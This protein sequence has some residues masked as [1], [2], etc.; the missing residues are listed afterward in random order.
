VLNGKRLLAVV[1][2]RGGS[3][4][5]PLKNLHP[6]MGRPLLAYAAATIHE[7]GCFD[8]GVVSTDH[9]EIAAVA[10]ASGLHVPFMRP[11]SLSG[12][13]IGD[14]PVLTHA[15][16]E[17]EASDRCEYDVI[18]ML[19]PTCPLRE[20]RHVLATVQRLIDEGWDAVWTVSPTDVK[21]HPLKA[22]TLSAN[23]ALALH[24]PRGSAIVAR[25]Q[26]EPVY[27][28]NGAA[29]AFTRECLLTQG[30]ILPAKAAA[31]VI[32]E[33]MISIDTLDDFAAVEGILKKRPDAGFPPEGRGLD[34]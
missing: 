24:D 3:K 19:Q 30:T 8:R 33:P 34:G 17:T 2:A 28:R 18:V 11:A 26:L 20:A 21:Y 23:G 25:Q 15:L 12:D 27:H 6:L 31:V 22:L 7:V 29:Y 4:G 32:Y 16:M 9:P 13:R 1:P 14:L 5:V 10:R